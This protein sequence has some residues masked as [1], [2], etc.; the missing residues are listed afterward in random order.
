[1]EKKYDY[2]LLP[3]LTNDQLRVLASDIRSDILTLVLNNGGHLS[4]NLGTVEL[5]MSL[6]QNFDPLKDDILFDVGHQTY[7]YKILTGR[8]LTY[9]RKTNG[10]APFSSMEESPFDKYNNGHA[11]TALSIAYGMAKAKA[12]KGDDSYTV[13]VVGDGSATTGL[14][15]EALNLLSTDK[16]TKLIVII[17]DNDMS[18]SPNVGFLS[19]KFEKLRNSRFYF[20]TSSRIGSQMS[21]HKFSWKIFLKMRSL[22]DHL[23]NAVI[24]PTI[25]ESMG[26]KYVGPFDGHD[27][28]SLALAFEKAKALVLRGPVVV[29]ILTIKGYGYKPAM[30]DK[31]GKYH[32]VV[33][34]F[35]SYD[36][37]K[38]RAPGFTDFKSNFLLKAMREDES[39][40][41]LTPAMENGSGLEKVFKA[42]PERSLDVGIAE[43]NCVSMAGGLA[44]KGIKPIIDIYSSF[45]QR[46]FDEIT[47]DVSHQYIKALFLVE[48]AGIVGEDGATHQGIYDVAMVK[49]IP[50]CR[51]YMPFDETTCMELLNE[52]LFKKEGPVFIR[53]P[54]MNPILNAKPYVRSDGLCWFNKK[55]NQF[56]VI[57][58]G[59]YGYQLLDSL[60]DTFDKALEMNLLPDESDIDRSLITQNYS[61]IFFYDAYGIEQGTSDSLASYLMKN[62]YQ[63]QYTSFALKNDFVTFGQKEEIYSQLGMDPLSVKK[64]ILAFLENNPTSVK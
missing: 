45:M 19:K 6:L 37:T 51:V 24:R 10:I 59:P 3:T 7:T 60:P 21:K 5:T 33:P 15:M 61:H 8:D 13:A 23:K 9:L 55:G 2:R 31:V 62:H 14:T 54:V 38:N 57:A 22:K 27:F 18:I 36:V 4:S 12:L 42:F 28:D 58:T 26:L 39:L 40:F 43:E 34:K 47:E 63:G 1:V 25:F 29:N 35:D 48:R 16:K 20:R 44:L 46:S 53:F 41:V 49:A 30:D 32:G 64:K 11:G 52:N 56:V 50:N 17:N